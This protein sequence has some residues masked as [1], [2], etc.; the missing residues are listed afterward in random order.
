[1]PQGGIDKGED[2]EAA[3]L[4]ELG[5][6]IGVQPTDVKIEKRTED[7]IT[8]DLPDHLLGRMWGGRFGGQKQIWFLMT[9]TAG[10]RAIN[11]ET[12]HPEFRAWRWST[13]TALLQD[14]VPFKRKVYAAVVADLLG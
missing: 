10:D 1:M 8:Y 11:I 5:E 7:W 3:A 6:E 12:A 13:S 9:L 14:I 2:P 4:R